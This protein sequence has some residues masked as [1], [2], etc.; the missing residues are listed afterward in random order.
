MT[1][2]PDNNITRAEFLTLLSRVF[3]WNIYTYPGSTTV[4]KDA[5][6]FGYFSDVIN[7]ATYY[8]Y[9]SGYTDGTFKPGNLISYAEVEIIMNRVLYYQSFR[10]VNIANSMLTKKKTRSQQ[11]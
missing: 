10:W 11:L 1:F 2:R 7:Y 9:I 3:K 4:F 8:N 5:G 6:T